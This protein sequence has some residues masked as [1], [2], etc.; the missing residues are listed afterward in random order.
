[1]KLPQ[2]N[3]FP[4]YPNTSSTPKAL[5][6]TSKRFITSTS[7]LCIYMILHPSLLILDSSLLILHFIPLHHKKEVVCILTN[8]RDTDHCSR[9]NARQNYCLI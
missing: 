2:G 3:A 8:V 7:S 9:I 6:A 4:P 5:P 1:M